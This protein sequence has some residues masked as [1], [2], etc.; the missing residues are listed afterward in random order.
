M[1][2]CGDIQLLSSKVGGLLRGGD[3][4]HDKFKIANHSHMSLGRLRRYVDFLRVL[5]QVEG[6]E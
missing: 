3:R 6:A 1:K 5:Y 2:E 4:N